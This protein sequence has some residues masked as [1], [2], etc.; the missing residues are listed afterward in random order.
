MVVDDRKG[1]WPVPPKCP[2]VGGHEGAG[3]IVAM[4]DGTDTQLKI[5]SPVGLKWL[6]DSCLNC[7]ACLGGQEATCAN[8]KLSGY[9]VDGSFQ[10]CAASVSLS[11]I[12]VSRN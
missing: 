12:R 3:R 7:E 6:A 8:A 2:L 11:V 9:T 5:G 1:D 4:G 10:Q